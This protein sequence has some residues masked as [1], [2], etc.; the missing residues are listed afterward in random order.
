MAQQADLLVDVTLRHDFIGA[1]RDGW[2]N[3][4]K[5]RNPDNPDQ[6]LEGAAAVK[7]QF[8]IIATP[9]LTT[10]PTGGF[11][12]CM[13]VYT[14]SGRIHGEFLRLLFSLVNKQADA[15]FQALGYYDDDQPHKQ[16]FCYLSATR[17]SAPQLGL[18]RVR[19]R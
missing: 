12:A 18:R 13:H 3:L 6:I 1:G 17:P 9:N 4:G 16:E 8:V 7:I 19:Q 2:I 10:Q 5:L 11:L 14:T 15:Y